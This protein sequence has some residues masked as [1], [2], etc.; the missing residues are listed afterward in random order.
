MYKHRDVKLR[1]Y[2]FLRLT[3]LGK[4][5][6]NNVDERLLLLKHVYSIYKFAIQMIGIFVFSYT[7]FWEILKIDNT[8][9]LQKT[10]CNAIVLLFVM[11]SEWK[12]KNLRTIKKQ[13]KT[14]QQQKK[15]KT[16]QNKTN[17]TNTKQNYDKNWGKTNRKC[18]K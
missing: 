16:K 2:I 15:K 6:S 18:T 5:D 11:Y 3:F 17:K 9:S 8:D 7:I 14:K 4:F 1:I 13:N 12:L 10:S